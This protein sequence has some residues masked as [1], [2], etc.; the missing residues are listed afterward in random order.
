M[1][2]ASG[3]CRSLKRSPK[4]SDRAMLDTVEGTSVSNETVEALIRAVPWSRSEE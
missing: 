4:G 2:S 1:L 3:T